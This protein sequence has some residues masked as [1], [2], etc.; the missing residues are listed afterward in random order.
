VK[1]LGLQL[2]T[3]RKES[4]I[5]HIETKDKNQSLRIDYIIAEEN[6]QRINYTKD[7]AKGDAVQLFDAMDL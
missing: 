6:S 4:N 3:I 5:I 1:S 2:F 7:N